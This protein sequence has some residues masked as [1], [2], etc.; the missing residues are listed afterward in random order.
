MGKKRGSSSV[1][2]GLSL[3]IFLLSAGS[4]L[5][6]WC[7]NTVSPELYCTQTTSTECCG[8]SCQ[9]GQ[10]VEGDKPADCNLGCCYSSSG[11]VTNCE[12]GMAYRG[13]CVN[14]GGVYGD[15]CTAITQC[16]DGCCCWTE[17]A[18]QSGV[19]VKGDCDRKGAS[20]SAAW[21][22]FIV[23]IQN[24][25][26]TCGTN[27]TNGTGSAQPQCN[28]T[29]DNDGDSLIDYPADPG[30]AST[31]DDSETNANAPCSDGVDNDN[32]GK[33]D[34]DDTCCAKYP[35][36]DE[37][38]CDIEPCPTDGPVSS[39]VAKCRCYD[40]FPCTGGQ[41]CCYNGC[42]TE[43][44]ESTTCTTGD[45]K[46]CGQFDDSGCELF[47]Y[48]VNGIWSGDCS[49]DPSCNKPF[50]ICTDGLDNNFDGNADCNDIVCHGMPCYPSEQTCIA[51][52][53]TD[54]TDTSATRRCC[55]TGVT[56]DCDSDGVKDTCGDC[57]CQY[58]MPR[59][60][61]MNIFRNLSGVVI[62][63]GLNCDA[64]N[65]IYKCTGICTNISTNF[66][67][68][69]SFTGDQQDSREWLDTNIGPKKQYCY[70]VE[71][72]Y[73]VGVK[74]SD[75]KCVN[76][77]DDACVQ[78]TSEFCMNTSQG[79][80][81]R[82]TTRARC[83]ANNQ[84]VTIEDCTKKGTDYICMGPYPSEGTKCMYQSNCDTC[85]EPLSMFANPI[86]SQATYLDPNS[87]SS[88]QMACK[89]I[90]TCYY[91]YSD[92][93]VDKFQ[94]CT[95]IDSCYRYRS[96]S[97][98]EEQ[99]SSGSNNKCLPR[100][101]SWQ[102]IPGTLDRGICFETVDR[103]RSCE[104]CNSAENNKIF[105]KCDVTRCRMFGNCYPRRIDG[106]CSDASV[107]TCNDF[108]AE[109]DCTGGSGVKVNVEYDASDVR[110]PGTVRR[111]NVV[112]KSNDVMGIGLCAWSQSIDP[113]CYKD[114]NGNNQPDPMPWDKS[115]PTTRVLTGQKVLS[116]NVSFQVSDY[117][118]NGKPGSGVKRL[119]L[120]Q[121]D[122]SYCYPTQAY[123]LPSSKILSEAWGGGHGLHH[124]Y[125]YAEDNA[126]N[127][128]VVREAVIEV[129]R[130]PPVITITPY[131]T[132]DIR[133]F[134]NSNITFLVT[135]SENATCTDRFESTVLSKIAKQHGSR[136]VVSYGGLS[137]GFYDYKVN[138][139]D[140]VGNV[141]VAYKT[142]HIDAD[143]M[144]YNPKPQG[145]ID[146][147][148]AQL[149]V[150]TRQSG[151][152]KFG[153]T[154]QQ[155]ANLPYQFN[156]PT[157]V[158][159]A[160]FYSKSF[161][162]NASGT[163]SFDVKCQ[164]G[165]T[166]H[167]DE[168]QFTYDVL[169]PVTRVLDMNGNV[170]DFSRWYRG[171]AG[172]V[173]LGCTDQPENGF[174]C[175]GTYYCLSTARCTPSQ[176][177]D[178]L[179]PVNYTLSGDA[180]AW[181]CYYSKEAK[182]G[183]FGG[184]DEEVVCKEIKIDH[185]V[186]I[187]TIARIGQYDAADD[188][189]TTF[190]NSFKLEGTV[191]DP[192]AGTAQD[193]TVVVA[194]T[195]SL[196]N[197]SSYGPVK[198]NKAFSQ[199]LTL[200]N[201][202]NIITVTATDRSGE[203]VQKTVYVFVADYSGAKIELIKP[204]RYGVSSTKSFELTVKTYKDA[205]CRFALNDGPYNS[206]EPM[207]KTVEPNGETNNY[208]HT[209]TGFVLPDPAE[210]DNPVYVKCKDV[211]GV[212]FSKMFNV[213]WDNTAPVISDLELDHSDGKSPP[214]VVEFP[215]ETNVIVTSDDRVRCK[216]SVGTEDFGC[217]MSKFDRFDNQSLAIENRQFF[218]SLTDMTS[219]SYYF[220]CENGAEL[221]SAKKMLLW[222]VD[223]SAAT[224]FSFLSPK[225][226]GSNETFSFILQTSK[227]TS[228]CTYGDSES[229]TNPL[230]DM[231]NKTHQSPAITLKEGT[232]TYYFSC[233]TY[234]EFISDS[235]TFTIDS[236]PPS[237]PIIDDG[238]VSWYTV[239]LSATWKS[240]DN[241]SKVIK[242]NYSIG[243]APGAT[244]VVGWRES[245]TNKVTVSGL[246]LTNGE[247]YYWSVMAM[248]EAGLW[249]EIGESDGVLI[250]INAEE[251]P[252]NGS[253]CTIP[254]NET[255]LSACYNGEQDSGESDID[256]G[257][258][259]AACK[260]GAK[261]FENSD[262]ESRNCNES[263][264]VMATC[265]DGIQNQAEG[266]IDCGGSCEPCD[267][268]KTCLIND[269]CG[270][271]YCGT[272][273]LCV[274]SSCDDGVQN[275]DETGTDCGGSCE[276]ACPESSTGCTV[277]EDSGEKDDSDCDGMPDYWEEQYD[278]DLLAD[279]S[280]EDPDND[281]YNN[282]EEYKNGTNPTVA[283]IV[284]SHFW[285][286]FLII[287]AL[288]IILGGG[289]YLGYTEYTKKKRPV[290]RSSMGGAPLHAPMG[291]PLPP[292]PKVKTPQQK[293]LDSLGAMMRRKR[294]DMKKGARAKIMDGFGDTEKSSADTS[295]I[296][297]RPSLK[298]EQ[299]KEEP[300]GKEPEKKSETLEPPKP[301][302]EVAEVKPE[303]QVE[304]KSADKK[305]ADKNLT[306][307]KIAEKKQAPEKRKGLEGLYEVANRRRGD[308]FKA[309]SKI[310]K[311]GKK[312]K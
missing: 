252:C 273:G 73:S 216:Y 299:P 179:Y 224:G 65:Y 42:F 241:L 52:G 168:I 80:G 140:D 147:S 8:G 141:G 228:D 245:K 177:Y 76:S 205:D 237:T 266:D 215:L 119:F 59:P 239:K 101:C 180:D 78:G 186:P 164:I 207:T 48:C 304:K 285:T 70:Y 85:G 23:D 96:K 45:R 162:L 102:D 193:N 29:Y 90:P 184:H 94:A 286:W 74:D 33:K 17:G 26:T 234:N 194:V 300:K 311:K 178:P 312:R 138:C 189:Y 111:D 213:S 185:N 81:G 301:P 32:D 28:D 202:L 220:Q 41:Y 302:K 110:V 297:E 83:D 306:D 199:P 264:C 244:D 221:R 86:T 153:T 16:E 49:P 21:H 1:L 159:G 54:A 131:V 36:K 209:K 124:I 206:A 69:A 260:D 62:R 175:N 35:D 126:D 277:T 104:Y 226:K 58:L 154:P 134:M 12:P 103:Y 63:F 100:G 195:N 169:S 282:L 173:F 261:C 10:Y 251:V 115:P 295:R 129:D 121:N 125:Y 190:D 151:T 218:G 18:K 50:E 161:A 225:K 120:C 288:V 258:T 139:T 108:A 44:C 127:L 75:I 172:K 308:A 200:W 135:V 56:S 283:D 148:P 4:A 271:R 253:G 192:D 118:S 6:G 2:I 267:L 130:A 240:E 257:G 223:T 38:F 256:C 289:S 34:V 263:I 53:Y 149:A 97:A 255:P 146:K 132:L 107:I 55:Y 27:Y 291:K 95:G 268:G 66:T 9:E 22:P 217:C 156:A 210:V 231:G 47:S 293:Y 229:P 20:Y 176:L 214:T 211:Q 279:D 165:T 92:T 37:D 31:A 238:T 275:G 91:D 243:T 305:P 307:K 143:S 122:S 89:D 170:F 113:H 248:N 191:D 183:G 158:D 40:S 174:G 249:S 242:Y 68:V 145:V 155:Y 13:L 105:D 259:C 123:S 11:T 270:S 167:D 128:E 61:I 290:A 246:N 204:N 188:F 198:A 77:G 3:V 60:Y 274:E 203:Q 163:Y 278:L 87:G 171:I 133:Q 281:N 114:A 39:Q 219:Y 296:V 303:K 280:R 84:I 182:I 235:Y 232:Y 233:K 117:Q 230:T 287:G 197:S 82:R 222:K 157:L 236:S 269:D 152:C 142:V 15:D 71:T 309:L 137:D 67:L 116:L 43:A 72:Q 30:C 14:A 298:K 7:L 212:L 265:S 262:C 294:Q 247:T 160:Y 109:T 79:I 250:D 64:S 284:K 93:S 150:N 166:V 201:G 292:P 99:G 310:A 112:T 254:G 196:G 25:S 144:I 227:T 46:S 5:A 181:L 19:M 98:C 136:W 276:S 88:Y 272:D 106:R 57:Q 208:Y 51:R 24:C 187:L